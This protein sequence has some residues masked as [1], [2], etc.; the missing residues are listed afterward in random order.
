MLFRLPQRLQAS[1]VEELLAQFKAAPAGEPVAV[2]VSAVEKVDTAGVQLL[3]S[4]A[5]THRPLAWQGSS[6]ALSAAAELLGLR[7]SLGL[8]LEPQ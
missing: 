1:Q 2:D 8:P 4:L 3:L 7:A 6:K 5:I